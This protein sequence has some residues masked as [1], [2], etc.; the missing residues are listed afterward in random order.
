MTFPAAYF[1]GN[2]IWP[3]IAEIVGTAFL[4]LFV[5]A[6]IDSDNMAV[7]T[8]LG[9]FMIGAAVMVIGI[10]LGAATGYPINPAREFGPRLFRLARRLGV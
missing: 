10:S 1:D 6:I 9:P 8:N 4:V 2:L 7:Q 5:F 3:L